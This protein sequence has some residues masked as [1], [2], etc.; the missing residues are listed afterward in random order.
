MLSTYEYKSLVIYDLQVS[1]QSKKSESENYHQFIKHIMKN[2]KTNPTMNSKSIKEPGKDQDEGMS[3][4]LSKLFE[5]G[6]KDIYWAEKTLVKALGKMRKSAG[7][8][9][10]VSAIE[11]HIT[12]TEKQVSRLEEVFSIIGKEPRGKKCEAMEGLIKEGETIMEEA[13]EGAMRDAGIIA[14]A[15]KVEHYE[16]SSY[17]TLRTYAETLGMDDAVAL[18]EETLEEEKDTDILLSDLATSSVN[19]LAAASELKK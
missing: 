6:L 2:P 15:Q 18:L 4:Q 7:S 19:L 16:I 10:L 8:K 9:E 13:E 12:Q 11:K 1:K 5:D 14:A 17:G 3:S